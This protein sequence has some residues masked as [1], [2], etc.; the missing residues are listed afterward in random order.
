MIDHELNLGKN[1][2]QIINEYRFG[3][4]IDYV[5]KYGKESLSDEDLALYEFLNKKSA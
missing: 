4:L 3:Y 1:K 2:N 5:N